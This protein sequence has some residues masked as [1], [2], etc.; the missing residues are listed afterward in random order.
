MLETIF[1]YLL[2]II[3]TIQ[4][5]LYYVDLPPCM[6]SIHMHRFQAVWSPSKVHFLRF[7]K[8][9]TRITWYFLHSFTKQMR[10]PCAPFWTSEST[11]TR[12][13]FPHMLTQYLKHSCK[14]NAGIYLSLLKP[15]ILSIPSVSDAY[16]IHIFNLA[17]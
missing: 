8:I 3:K 12:C 11:G 6:S 4:C 2:H 10:A 7:K 15:F 17:P 5:S 1:I 13:S 16:R 9:I 14:W